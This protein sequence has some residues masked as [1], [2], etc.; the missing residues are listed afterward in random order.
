MLSCKD[1]SIALISFIGKTKREPDHKEWLQ[2]PR[3]CASRT[4][5]AP[6]HYNLAKSTVAA[7]ASTNAARGLNDTARAVNNAP[8]ALNRRCRL[9][10]LAN[11]GCATGV[12]PSTDPSLSGCLD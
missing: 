1:S 9:A 8:N 6:K 3:R 11:A 12:P 10:E 7:I 2:P 4:E 5:Y